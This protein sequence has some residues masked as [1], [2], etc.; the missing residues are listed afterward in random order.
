MSELNEEQLKELETLG[1][2]LFSIRD[3]ALVLEVPASQL[4]DHVDEPDSAASKAYHRGRLITEL[5][6][7]QAVIKS[8][9]DGSNPAQV[10][11]LQLIKQMNQDNA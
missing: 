6:T 3:C 5:A 8:A 4:Q 10:L 1:A 2:A 11:A 9:S 7:R